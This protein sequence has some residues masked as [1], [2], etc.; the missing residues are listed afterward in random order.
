MESHYKKPVNF[1]LKGFFRLTRVPNLLII[2]LT[3][4]MAAI[5]LV[6]SEVDVSRYLKS[7]E[8]FLLSLSTILIAAAGYI[9]N[10]YYDVKIDYI[11]KPNRVVVGKILKRRVVMAAHTGLN[12]TGILI[13]S[14]LSLKVG[15]LN[16]M[17]AFL[18]WLY[19]NQL[20]RLPFVGNLSIAVLSGAAIAVIGLYY[21]KHES[22]IYTYA[23][24]AFSITL[25]REVIK[26]ME[27]LQG[28][29][30][31]GCKTLPVVLG[32]RQTKY[33]LYGLI[34]IFVF[35]LFYLSSQLGNPVLTK[36]FMVLILP[37]IYFV[38]RLVIADTKNEFTFLSHFSKALI[39]S[40][41]ISMV[42]F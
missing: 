19:S 11:N 26:D 31:F 20:K 33:I 18:L 16:F 7:T 10:D 29:Q 15:M 41:I 34:A 40:G 8:L 4:Y 17:A 13:G 21:A 5:F 27:D 38:Y 14:Y 23:I 9:I 12:L 32:I 22:L 35:S 36:Y 2:A 28:D 39:L 3:Q 6:G 1:S 25:V 30:H 37:I 42:F 24:F